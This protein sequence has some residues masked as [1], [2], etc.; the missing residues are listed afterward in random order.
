MRDIILDYK[1]L[2]VIHTQNC[3]VSVMCSRAEGVCKDHGV[4]SRVV[5]AGLIYCEVFPVDG[6]MRSIVQS[7]S[8]KEPPHLSGISLHCAVIESE[9]R[10]TF[11]GLDRIGVHGHILDNIC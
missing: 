4:S 7:K 3:N 6:I 2:N 9:H 8:I 5:S 11:N 10:C 1:L